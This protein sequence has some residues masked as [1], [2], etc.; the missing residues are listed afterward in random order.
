MAK[1]NNSHILPASAASTNGLNLTAS[2]A[3]V[4]SISAMNT[5]AAVKF[6][7]VY[8]SKLVPN[9]VTDIP[10]IIVPLAPSNALTILRFPSTFYCNLGISYTITGLSAHSDATATAAGDVVGVNILYS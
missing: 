10:V 4:H 3:D 9:P 7:K 2:P 1:S 6:L 5:T 8:N